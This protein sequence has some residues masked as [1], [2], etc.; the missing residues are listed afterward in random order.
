MLL[1]ESSG[2]YGIFRDLA[3]KYHWVLAVHHYRAVDDLLESLEDTVL[4]SAEEKAKE[5]EQRGRNSEC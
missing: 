1:K 5:L 4:R 2:E 3:A